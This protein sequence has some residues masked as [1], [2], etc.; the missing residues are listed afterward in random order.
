MERHPPWALPRFI[1]LARLAMFDVLANLA[2]HCWP[3]ISL[4]DPRFRFENSH[5]AT[6]VGIVS[7]L[8][9]FRTNFL[10]SE[11]PFNISR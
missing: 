11:D 10:W 7:R 9:Y 5:V 2:V 6:Q 1:P 3:K 4:E 8:D